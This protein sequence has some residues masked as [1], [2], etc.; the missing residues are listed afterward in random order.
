[1][2]NPQEGVVFR[3]TLWYTLDMNKAY[4]AGLIDGEG[5]FGIIPLKKKGSINYS[6]TCVVKIALSGETA[7]PVLSKIVEE[8]NGYL[9]KRRLPTATGKEVWT[10]EIKNKPRVKPLLT[11]IYPYLQVKK[12]QA[13]LMLE[14]VEFPMINPRHFRFDQQMFDRRLEIVKQ[15][16]S[17]TQR[18]P[19]ATTN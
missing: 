17:M 15:L 13:E 4:L 2:G 19:L 6:Y 12:K 5:Y 1:V 7:Y 3:P 14:F 11:D 18:T 8:Y 9:F 16:K 10:A